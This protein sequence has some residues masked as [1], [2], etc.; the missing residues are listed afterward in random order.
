MMD[1]TVTQRR[2]AEDVAAEMRKGLRVELAKLPPDATDD[3][4]LVVCVAYYEAVIA[5]LRERAK[6]ES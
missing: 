1:L 3:Q 5:T 2:L 6:R 4:K